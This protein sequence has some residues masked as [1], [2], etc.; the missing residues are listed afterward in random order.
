MRIARRLREAI[1]EA[2]TASARDMR[3]DAVESHFSCLVRVEAFIEEV[4]QKAPVLRDAL[5][6]NTRG[7]Q[8][9]SLRRVLRVRGEIA[10]RRE[11]QSGND[12]ILNRI[13]VL[14][15]PPG[16]ETAIQMNVPVLGV[17]FPLTVSANCH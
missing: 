15:N 1:V 10:N 6:I 13:H 11:T 17:S 5:T 3:E 7:V 4:S 9:R 2:A 14:V 12:R 8:I 16:L